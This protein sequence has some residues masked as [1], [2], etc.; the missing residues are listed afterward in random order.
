MKNINAPVV[1]IGLRVDIFI[2]R[3]GNNLF[4]TTNPVNT[5]NG[6]EFY[7]NNTNYKYGRNP[8]YYDVFITH[9]SDDRQRLEELLN[10]YILANGE[11]SFNNL[12]HG[13]G[14]FPYRL[15]ENFMAIVK[16]RETLFMDCAKLLETIK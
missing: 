7:Y 2:I 4:D 10:L 15:P 11:L 5:I 9:T 3:R 13:L 16:A 1:Y 6:Y 8:T 12:N 14:G